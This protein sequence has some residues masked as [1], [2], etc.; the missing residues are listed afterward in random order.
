MANYPFLFFAH[1]IFP[2]DVFNDPL[3]PKTQS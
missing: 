1:H 2:Q 3:I